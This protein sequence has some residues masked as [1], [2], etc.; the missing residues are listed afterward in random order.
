MVHKKEAMHLI[1]GYSMELDC[2]YNFDYTV[3]FFDLAEKFSAY[4]MASKNVYWW[5]H[6]SIMD[7]CHSEYIEWNQNVFSIIRLR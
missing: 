5:V 3:L 1:L 4:I 2:I 6:E 7:L